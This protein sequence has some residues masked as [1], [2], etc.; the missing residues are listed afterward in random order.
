MAK[1]MI[2]AACMLLLG[3]C[4]LPV[5]LQIASWAADGISFVMTKKSLT[6]HGLSMVAQKDC[7]LLRAVVEGNVCRD[8]DAATMV[9]DA[10]QGGDG[11][12]P[13]ATD[14]VV[15]APTATES[16]PAA[17]AA[18]ASSDGWKNPDELS[19]ENLAAFETASG[20][21]V[22]VSEPV[23][24]SSKGLFGET[25]KVVV[26]IPPPV[27]A[28]PVVEKKTATVP[29][30]VA[31]VQPA[32]E[33]PAKAKAKKPW[34]QLVAAKEDKVVTVAVNDEAAPKLFMVMGSFSKRDNALGLARRF[35]DMNPYVLTSELNGRKI[36]RVAI[37]AATSDGQQAVRHQLA[38][39]GVV[40]VWAARMDA[41]VWTVMAVVKPPP[42]R[43]PAGPSQL[44][45][46]VPPAGVY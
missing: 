39:I 43:R 8:D 28:S 32:A 24:V 22:A 2:L 37:G 19:A 46:V 9:A 5:P 18:L 23:P 16:K 31:A 45:R 42:D 4:A 34:Q 1:R 12:A 27:A 36:Y 10:S 17:V 33:F 38:R 40:D 26:D 25:P 15:V 35:A 11:A 6:D 29:V 14:A 3:G 41:S 7:A 44:A 21:A 20:N 13:V 30:Q